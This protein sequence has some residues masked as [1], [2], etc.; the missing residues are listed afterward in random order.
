MSFRINKYSQMSSNVVFRLKNT[1]QVSLEEEVLTRVFAAM[2]PCADLSE[3]ERNIFLKQHIKT[4][5]FSF[6]NIMLL[7]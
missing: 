3:R 6:L 5:Y 4:F 7:F 1:N 2:Y